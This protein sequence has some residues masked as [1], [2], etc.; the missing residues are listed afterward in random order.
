[1]RHPLRG[2]LDKGPPNN[3]QGEVDAK[4]KSHH[5]RRAGNHNRCHAAASRPSARDGAT[6][7]KEEAQLPP[8]DGSD[9]VVTGT[10]IRGA[11]IAGEVITIDQQ[12]IIAAGQIDVG[13]AIR[14]LPQNFGGG[15]NPGIGTGAGL[16]NSNLNSASSANLRGLGPD[17]T[18]TL[19]NGH[20]LPYDSA[21]QGRPQTPSRA[22][23]RKDQ[24]RVV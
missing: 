10:R 20:R 23:G 22:E 8:E 2:E 7:K 21:F 11:E 4:S 14:S 17:A 19:L 3:D 24:D 16:V 5:V 9:I 6:G 1:M 18:L 15:Q 12:T 13:E